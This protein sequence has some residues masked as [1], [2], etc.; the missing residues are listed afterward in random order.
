MMDATRAN[1]IPLKSGISAADIGGASPGSMGIGKPLKSILHMNP[2]I[3]VW[4]GSGT[5][6]NVRMAAEVAD[7]ILPL[8][9]VPQTAPMYR[10]WVE[11]GFARAGNGKGWK[12]F[13]MQICAQ[14]AGS[15]AS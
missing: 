11:E 9:F 5:E 4:L 14:Q 3:P 12:D 8:G 10:K 2:N 13:E 1:G 15:C 7:G 6:T